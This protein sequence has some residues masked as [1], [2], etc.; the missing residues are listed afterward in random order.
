M[1]PDPDPNQQPPLPAATDLS[2]AQSLLEGRQV[3]V[4]PTETQYGLLAGLFFSE[5]LETILKLK[6]RDRSCP[7]PCI[8]GGENDLPKV[9]AQI[10][11]LH[12]R[13]MDRFWPGPLTLIFDA[14]PEVPEAVTGQSGSI[15][16]RVPGLESARVLAARTGPLVATSANR[17]GQP[18]WLDAREIRDQFAG[19][20]VFDGGRLVPSQGSTVLDVRGP[21]PKLIR[22]GAVPVSA[23]EEILRFS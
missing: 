22:D 2:L 16:V 15:G 13:L 3:I 8:I 9:A 1:D 23:L 7:M 10:S 12:Q 18:P 19:V 5:A 21:K 4:Y 17:S 6:G 14:T 20:T 11:E